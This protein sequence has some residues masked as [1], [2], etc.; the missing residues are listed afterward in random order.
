MALL[1][2]ASGASGTRWG[3][4]HF[5][6]VCHATEMLALNKPEVYIDNAPQKLDGDGNPL[7]PSAQAA[8]R[9]LVVALAAWIERTRPPA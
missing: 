2:A 4:M 8:I 3:Q 5:R 9:D 7:D 6:Q 1:G